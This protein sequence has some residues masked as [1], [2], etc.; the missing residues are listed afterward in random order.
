MLGALVLLFG[1][2][3]ADW[4]V[5][6]QYVTCVLALILCVFAG[7]AKRWW[8]LAGLVPIVVLWNPVWPIPGLRPVLPLLTIAAAVVFVVAG[9]T[10]KIPAES[11][12]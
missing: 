8:W 4:Y 1:L 10:I 6:V 2:A 5:P 9:L 11:R 3:L 7:Q 12:R